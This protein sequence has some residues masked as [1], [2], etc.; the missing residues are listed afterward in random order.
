MPCECIRKSEKN[1][2]LESTLQEASTAVRSGRKVR[3][4][5][6]SLNIPESTLRDQLKGNQSNK[7][8]MGRK[9]VFNEEQENAIANHFIKLANVFFGITPTEL[10]SLAYRFAEMNKIKNRFIHEKNCWSRLA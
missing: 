2:W 5:G 9:H 10:R 3:E 6:R 8:Q 7:L 4:V 1:E